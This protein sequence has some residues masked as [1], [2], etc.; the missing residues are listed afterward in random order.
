MPK[1][2]RLRTVT[3]DEEQEVRCIA[4]SRTAS[5]R[6]AQRA[7][8]IVNMLDRP[9]LTASD[10]GMAAGFASNAVGPVWVRRFNAAGVAGLNDRPRPGK[11]RT[12]SHDPVHS[13]SHECTGS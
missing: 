12:H 4:K 7:R 11:P 8:I 3:L 10:A 5:V 9:A 13:P 1:Y 6:S 2:V